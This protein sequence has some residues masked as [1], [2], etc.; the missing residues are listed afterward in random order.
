MFKAVSHDTLPSIV[1]DIH[2]ATT[3]TDIKRTLITFSMDQSNSLIPIVMLHPNIILKIITLI[4]E[5]DDDNSKKLLYF[6]W[7][8]KALIPMQTTNN[9]NAWFLFINTLCENDEELDH[10]LLNRVLTQELLNIKLPPT[11]K[12]APYVQDF[13]DTLMD[14]PNQYFGAALAFCFAIENPAIENKLALHKELIRGIPPSTDLSGVCLTILKKPF[15][16]SA[17]EE[18]FYESFNPF[19]IS[20]IQSSTRF[21][22][23][24]QTFNFLMNQSKATPITV[25]GPVLNSADWL[26]RANRI[27]HYLI[28][29]INAVPEADLAKAM[30]TMADFHQTERSGLLTL[31]LQSHYLTKIF[32]VLPDCSDRRYLEIPT[33]I[34]SDVL[35]RMMPLKPINCPTQLVDPCVKALVDSEEPRLLANLLLILYILTSHVANDGSIKKPFLW[36]TWLLLIIKDLVNAKAMTPIGRAMAELIQSLDFFDILPSKSR[37]EFFDSILPPDPSITDTN[38]QAIITLF[39]VEEEAAVTVKQQK[40]SK[41][42]ATDLG[43]QGI[44]ESEKDTDQ[45]PSIE[46]S[47]ILRDPVDFDTDL[48]D[49]TLEAATAAPISTERQASDRHILTKTKSK[50]EK[51]KITAL[52]NSITPTA[53]ETLDASPL[54]KLMKEIAQSF[55]AIKQLVAQMEKK[56]LAP[57]WQV[58]RENVKS[59]LMQIQAIM[60]ALEKGIE[61]TQD[62]LPVTEVIWNEKLAN[63]CWD[64]QRGLEKYFPMPMPMPMPMMLTEVG[65]TSTQVQSFPGEAESTDCSLSI[66]EALYSALFELSIGYFKDP[67]PHFTPAILTTLKRIEAHFKGE[68]RVS[69]KGSRFL[70]SEDSDD[71]DLEL[72]PCNE[73]PVEESQIGRIMDGSTWLRDHVIVSG[74]IKHLREKNKVIQ[75]GIELRKGSQLIKI[76][77]NVLLQKKTVEEELKETA[78]SLLTPCAVNWHLNGAA[79]MLPKTARAICRPW[80]VM[81]LLLELKSIEEYLAVSGYFLNKII[82][83]NQIVQRYDPHMKGFIEQYLNPK[84][85]YCSRTESLPAQRDENQKIIIA[86]LTYVFAPFRFSTRMRETIRYILEHKLLDV[87]FPE[88][89]A[90]RSYTRCRSYFENY[91]LA[92]SRDF[93]EPIPPA[94]FLTMYFIGACIDDYYAEKPKVLAILESAQ[95]NIATVSLHLAEIIKQTVGILRILP[96]SSLALYACHSQLKK[97]PD[98]MKDDFLAQG[99]FQVSQLWHRRVFASD[100]EKA[101]AQRYRSLLHPVATSY[102]GQGLQARTFFNSGSQPLPIAARASGQANQEDTQIFRHP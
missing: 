99:F 13:L 83:F 45:L 84:T 1:S 35:I 23:W 77:L 81:G 90:M 22:P 68:F 58:C 50:S 73:K 43:Q 52:P 59:K 11:Q 34:I 61:K 60:P 97:M 79:S 80:P 48:C 46:N 42:Q 69:L 85:R 16:P 6:S 64:L 57:G 91:F 63:F 27:R 66:R 49:T 28:N 32:R 54:D 39:S 14:K 95:R 12:S 96:G 71:F 102:Q 29:A 93:L 86:G 25:S 17:I 24:I 72:I 53:T 74:Q 65:A 18:Q 2:K 10:E 92:T 33:V 55:N 51:Q 8:S 56:S 101:Q 7:L 37:K 36:R 89:F 30:R 82:K 47:L 38:V 44:K 75:H 40:K 21:S 94:V 3:F 88:I 98:E 70:R 100:K 67:S 5:N 20:D 31:L 15:L 41:K 78:N 26:A 76:D 87:L 62:A 19:L 9:Y 4:I